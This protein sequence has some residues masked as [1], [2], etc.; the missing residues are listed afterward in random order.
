MKMKKGQIKCGTKQGSKRMG[1]LALTVH[2]AK[3]TL[4]STESNTIY[5]AVFWIYEVSFSP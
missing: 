3:N 4:S 5:F 1:L 2:R